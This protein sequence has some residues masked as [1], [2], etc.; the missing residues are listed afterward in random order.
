[1]VIKAYDKRLL[2]KELLAAIML[3]ISVLLES[4]T[5][6]MVRL[7]CAFDDDQGVYLVFDTCTHGDLGRDAAMDKMQ[8][9]F[10]VSKVLVPLLNSLD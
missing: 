3:E 7:E 6:G 9:G 1:M 5:E 10:V 2:D 8:E 4:P